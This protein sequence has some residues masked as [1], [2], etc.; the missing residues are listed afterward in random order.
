[1]VNPQNSKCFDIF[2][3]ASMILDIDE[4]YAQVILLTL[5]TDPRPE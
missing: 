2:Q 4:S 5:K 3:V 1:M